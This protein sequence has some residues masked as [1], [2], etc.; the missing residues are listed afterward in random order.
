MDQP[1]PINIFTGRY[2]IIYDQSNFSPFT[3]IVTFLIG[4]NLV[5]ECNFD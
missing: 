1:Y 2:K 4:K 5:M 3:F